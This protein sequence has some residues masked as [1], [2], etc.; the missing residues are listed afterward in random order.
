MDRSIERGGS[1]TSVAAMLRHEEAV[2]LRQLGKTYAEIGEGMGMSRQQVY[3]L[4]TGPRP[5]EPPPPGLW[6]TIGEAA[7]LLHLHANTLRRWAEQGIIRTIRIGTRHDRRFLR[8]DVEAL[9]S[10][11]SV[12]PVIGRPRGPRLDAREIEVLQLVADGNTLKRIAY[13]QNGNE[14]SLKHKTAAIKR[15]L[16]AKTLTQA[17]KIAL[18]KGIIT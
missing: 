10:D 1:R 18:L 13:D 2:R 5:K 7:R 3:Y 12:A 14:R 9:L 6:M 8:E 17:V 4:I 16:D 11:E 15:K